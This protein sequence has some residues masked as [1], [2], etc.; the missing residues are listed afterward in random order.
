MRLYNGIRRVAIQI[1]NWIMAH[2]VNRT[3]RFKRSHCCA[4][5]C[6]RA[7]CPPRCILL[8]IDLVAVTGINYSVG[9]ERFSQKAHSNVLIWFLFYLKFMEEGGGRSYHLARTNLWWGKVSRSFDK[10]WA[11]NNSS[12]QDQ[13]LIELS[14]TWKIIKNM[15]VKY[16][17]K[18][19]V[20]SLFQK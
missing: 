11:E 8:W 14:Q 20:L 3:K 7:I 18:N 17:Y 19:G 13:F 10:Y 2:I 1:I 16:Y 12:L 9:P 6:K 15:Q 4:P 5:F